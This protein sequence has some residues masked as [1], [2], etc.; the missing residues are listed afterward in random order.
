MKTKLCVSLFVENI[1]ET[2]FNAEKAVQLGAEVIEFRLDTV[3]QESFLLNDFVQQL[4][5]KNLFPKS[6]FTVRSPKEFGKWKYSERERKNFFIEIAKHKPAFLDVEFSNGIK[7]Y[8]QLKSISPKTTFILS[9][10]KKQ[11]SS[12]QLFSLCEIMKSFNCDVIKI[13]VETKSFE[14]TFPIF[15]LLERAKKENRKLIAIGMGKN[16]EN[17]RILASKYNAFLTFA[18][19]DDSMKTASGQI[20]LEKLLN[21]YNFKKLNSRTKVFGLIGNPVSHSKGIYVH[22]EA[23]RNT[24][25]NAV[26]VNCEMSTVTQLDKLYSIFDGFSVTAPYKES[27]IQFLDSIS[28][29]ANEIGAVNTITKRNGKLFGNN[30]D[31]NAFTN[32][33][34]K[35]TRFHN[36]RIAILGCGGAAKSIVAALKAE[37]ANVTIFNRTMAKITQLSKIYSCNVDSLD[38]FSNA[39]FDILIN[40]IPFSISKD[41]PKIFSLAHKNWEKKIVCDIVYN[42][43]ETPLL[44]IAKGNGATIVLG[45]KMFLNQAV[46]QFEL[47]TGKKAPI[48]LMKSVL[49]KSLSDSNAYM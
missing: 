13:A 16:G 1:S 49:V 11:L 25:T 15:S 35:N 30:F 41:F 38:N 4:K 44:N 12:T 28:L 6:I 19:L 9:S 8:Q 2:I 39:V 42:P 22:N 26:Y 7:F 33:F 40:T 14:Q 31:G 47:F 23:F 48:S 36:K 10:H 37:N 34:P 5:D 27:V 32:S 17:T 21:V 46:K 43:M 3:E 20:S 24:H 45:W 18:S 29:V